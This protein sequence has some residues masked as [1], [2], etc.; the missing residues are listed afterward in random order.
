M[1]GAYLARNAELAYAGNVHVAQGRNVHTAHLLVTESLS[2]QALY[3]DMTRGR[4]WVHVRMQRL[5]LRRGGHSRTPAIN[6]PR[7]WDGRPRPSQRSA[8]GQEHPGEIEMEL[9]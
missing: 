3:V 2:W 8:G 7:G 6:T 5:G 4:R 9:R 1:C